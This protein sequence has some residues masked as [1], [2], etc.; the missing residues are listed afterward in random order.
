MK[1]LLAG[2]GINIQFGGKAYTSQFIIERMKCRAAIQ[3]YDILFENT[4]S[5]IELVALFNGFVDIVKRIL[6]GECDDFDMDCDLKAALEDFQARYDESRY[7]KVSYPHDIMLEDWLFVLKMYSFM[8]D[9]ENE[10]SSAEIGFKRLFLDAIYNDGKIQNVYQNMG[11]KVYR[12]FK[13]FDEIYTVNYDTNLESATSKQ[14]FH[15]HGT[16]TELQA[17]ENPKYVIGYQKCQA[18]ESVVIPSF[19]H[20]FCNALLSYSGDLKYKEAMLMHRAN[21]ETE[22]VPLLQ[23]L[24][25]PQNEVKQALLTHKQH[26]ELKMAPE[27]Y[28]DRFEKITGELYV[29][30]MSPNND[31]HIIKIIKNN[32]H[33]TEIN[34]YCYTDAEKESVKNIGDT[35]FKAKDAKELWQSLGVKPPKKYGFKFPQNFCEPLNAICV[36]SDYQATEEKI[37]QDITSIPPFE[38]KRLCDETFEELKRQDAIHSHPKDFTVFKRNFAYISHIATKEGV[39]PPSLLALLILN[40]KNYT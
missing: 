1:T 17:S 2:N 37:R 28:F 8:Y 23:I 39:L 6:S 30:G 31:Q 36:L 19:E 27:Y 10:S 24:K 21:I 11:K 32:P 12:F 9:T 33:I 26:P 15:L 35:R 29:V 3:K 7:G 38:I 34:F 14:V 40:W 16:F 4:I 13:G 20:S 22:N 18:G 5:S 25:V